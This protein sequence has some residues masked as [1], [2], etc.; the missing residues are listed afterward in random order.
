MFCI[1]C[2]TENEDNNVFCK[3]CGAKLVKPVTNNSGNTETNSQ[4]VV[5]NSGVAH[6]HNSMKI[7]MIVGVAVIV[8]F[9]VG[10]LS[11]KKESSSKV[12]STVQV[13]NTYVPGI[14]SRNLLLG[15]GNVELQITVDKDRISSI[16]LTNVDE[17]ITTLYPL[18]VPTLNELSEIIISQQSIENISYSDESPYTSMLL[19]QIISETLSLAQVNDENNEMENSQ[20]P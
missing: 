17:S 16:N 12:V 18:L 20:I 3:N 2:G 7:V 19:M 8:I 11:V 14:Y 10:G 1:K 4:S 6:A 5:S 9:V 15:K 13:T